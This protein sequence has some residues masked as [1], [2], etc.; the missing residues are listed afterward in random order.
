MAKTKN[1]EKELEK[2]AL[3][4]VCGR[5]GIRHH[6]Q[7]V[8]YIV[9]DS[10][11]GIVHLLCVTS[12]KVGAYFLVLAFFPIPMLAFLGAIANRLALGRVG[13]SVAGTSRNIFSDFKTADSPPL[14]FLG[15][16]P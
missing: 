16:T 11:A 5:K 3:S 2:L 15:C 13:Q 6:G 4:R 9:E 10:M 12:A 8:F 14:A 7:H 1:W